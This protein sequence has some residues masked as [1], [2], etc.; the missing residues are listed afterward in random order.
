M[1]EAVRRVIGL[2][3][4]I[5]TGKSTVS[6][7]LASRYGLLVL[8]ADVFS[9]EAVTKGSEI[10]GLVRDRYGPTILLPDGNLNRSQLGQIIFSNAVEKQWIEQQIHPYVRARFKEETDAI[11]LTQTLVYSIPLLFEA[12]LTHLVTEI[13]VV[14]CSPEQ[15]LKRLI[16]RSHLTE[17]EAQTRI[18]AQMSLKEKCKR[19]NEVLDNSGN[20]ERLL[21]QIDRL[22]NVLSL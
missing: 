15:Q 6:D 4:G 3:G 12:K 5:A 13:W 18:D 11:A 2:T 20:K 8:D 16:K 7:Y 1:G 9:R 22:A 21:L 10:L 17:N 14:A 19:A